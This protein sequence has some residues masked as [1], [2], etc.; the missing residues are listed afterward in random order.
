MPTILEPSWFSK[1]VGLAIVVEHLEVLLLV[2]TFKVKEELE[3][4]D[5]KIIVTIEQLL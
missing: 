2:V 4:L 1:W 3:N 5:N